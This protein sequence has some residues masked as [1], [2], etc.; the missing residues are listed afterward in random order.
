VS[1]KILVAD[2]SLTVRMDLHDAFVAAGFEAVAAGGT[3]AAT[4]E[5]AAGGF[6]AIV[7]D[8]Q[9]DDAGLA[10]LL[11]RLRTVPGAVALPIVVLGEGPLTEPVPGLPPQFAPKPYEAGALVERVRAIVRGIRG[12]RSVLIIDDSATFR[13]ALAEAMRAKG[14]EVL[15]ASTG[16]EGLRVAAS[17]RPSMT[18]VD[19][20]LPGID[21]VT[22][23][24]R[25][26]SD[27]ALRRMPCLLLTASGER[28]DEIQGLE[29]GADAYVQKGSDVEL[30]LARI[31]AL[32][33]SAG[34]ASSY[35][36][37]ILPSSAS[38]V[39]AV[40]D[41]R[42]F[43]DA[44]ASTLEE[45]G[46]EPVLATGG[47]EALRA[48]KRQEVDCIL[49][50]LEMPGISGLEACRRIKADPERR[51]I[52]LIILTGR[53]DRNALIESLEAGADDYVAKSGDFEVLK[54]RLRA[55]VR[56]KRQ[57]DEGRRIT[58][59]LLRREL[60]VAEAS[61]AR[62]LAETRAGLLADLAGKNAELERANAELL[63]AKDAAEAATRAK[64]A[65]VA[66]MSH[67]I[68]TPMNGIIGMSNLLLDTRLE[69]EQRG[70]AETV[71]SCAQS[72]LG[73]I[74][75]LL[76]FSKVE[77]GKLELETIDFNLRAVV[78]D[79]VALLAEQARAKGIEVACILHG[80]LPAF[81]GGDPGRLRQ[82]L[83]NLVSNAVKFTARGEVVVRVEPESR[84]DG[85]VLARFSVSDT[86][87]GILPEVQKRL[88]QPFTQADSSTTR[89]YG[90]SG[91]GLAISKRLSGLMGGDIGVRSEPGKGSTFWFTAL[92]Q[93]R[94]TPIEPDARAVLRLQG[95]KVLCVDAPGS[96]REALVEQLEAVGAFCTVV[97]DAAAA[98]ALMRDGMGR[99]ERLDAVVFELALADGDGFGFARAVRSDPA[100][101]TLPLVLLTAFPQ[102]GQG[103]EARAAGVS[104]YLTKPVRLA[105]LKECLALVLSAAAS[106]MFPSLVTK[107]TIA[108]NSVLK[109]KRVL[110]AEDNAVNQKVAARILE[111]L[112]CRVDAVGN[113]RE[114]LEAVSS[115]PYD[116]V[117]MDCQ[118]PEMDGYEASRLIRALPPPLGRIPIIAMTANAM[119]GDRELCL[120]AGMDDYL[121]KPIEAAALERV[122]QTRLGASIEAAEAAPAPVDEA[123]L[124]DAAAVARLRDAMGDQDLVEAMDLWSKDAGERLRAIV[125]ARGDAAALNRAAHHFAGMSL[126]LGLARLGAC[127]RAIEAAA[128]TGDAAAAEAALAALPALVKESERTLGAER[129]AIRA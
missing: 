42:T 13:G 70:Y 45:E 127:C 85:K 118:M 33:R 25:L 20:Q 81:T 51:H 91:L 53:E 104:A 57:E 31:A 102:R 69:G 72:L 112:G 78:E 74:N 36:L 64:S 75:D 121:S 24:R 35:G 54:G 129:A 47:E 50:D 122:L 117:L 16:E 41:S 27:P 11:R 73:L 119:A 111:K 68:R 21:G 128:R 9:L 76:D 92:L 105:Q 101:T 4:A 126:T 2:R 94:P 26:K 114:A 48:L 120:A 98:L 7:V 90:G 18:V 84:A 32:A 88:F 89:R 93:E 23:I 12:G 61:A 80:A 103:P 71:R 28:K 66:T 15:Q 38:R 58:Q 106:G 37:A 59:E 46:H 29:A 99:G 62:E 52:P 30:V 123:P 8:A 55:Q 1:Q 56:R 113:G 97:D 40:D 79:A 108:E 109:R 10:T 60:E 83:L 116:A 49:L 19:G 86:G 63:V 67:E 100:W 107:H 95:T 65:F 82:V 22:V 96:S 115:I 87:I 44:L 17:A 110:L 14:Y 3:L 125:D 6:A 43:L 39:L 34:D 124:L 77:A 5:L